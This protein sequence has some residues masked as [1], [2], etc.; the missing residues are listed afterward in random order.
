MDTQQTNTSLL[1]EKSIFISSKQQQQQQQKTD[2]H[3]QK[4]NLQHQIQDLLFGSVIKN[5][6]HVV[7]KTLKVLIY[8]ITFMIVCWY[9]R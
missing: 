2:N 6:L 8:F 1:G 4:S 7:D 5:N 3:E 9:G